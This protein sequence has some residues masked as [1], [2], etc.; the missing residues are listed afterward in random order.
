MDKKEQLLRTMMKRK[1]MAM[2]KM[3]AHR[4]SL[5]LP[6]ILEKKEVNRNGSNSLIRSWSQPSI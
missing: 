6:P 5:H 2:M 3:M 1:V 4:N